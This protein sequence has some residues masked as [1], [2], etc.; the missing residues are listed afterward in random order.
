VAAALVSFAAPSAEAATI[1][2]RCPGMPLSVEEDLFARATRLLADAGMPWLSL[3]LECDPT[4]A[5]LIWV[6]GTRAPIDQSRGI[7][8]GVLEAIQN[9]IAADRYP[10]APPVGVHPP[11]QTAAPGYDSD[12]AALPRDDD[13]ARKSPPAETGLDKHGTEGGLGLATVAQFWSG[14]SFGVGPRLDVSVGPPGKFAVLLGEQA[15]FG[16]GSQGSGAV[17]F[18]FQVG[19]AYGAPFKTRTGFGAIAMLGAERIS[20]THDNASNGLNAWTVTGNLGARGSLAVNTINVWLGAD[21]LV[22]SSDF[23]TGGPSA[24]SIPSAS[25]VLSLGCFLPAFAK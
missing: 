7:V 2:V 10:P 16:T 17:V 25:F 21:L 18:D 22:R 14:G 23:Q 9:R 12:R 15:L 3:G 5:W 1:D 11:P 6:D 4:G 20:A 24:V 8:Q 13:N 19:G